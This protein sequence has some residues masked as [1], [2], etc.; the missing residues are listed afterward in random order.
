M[1]LA[2]VIILVSLSQAHHAVCGAEPTISVHTLDSLWSD[3]L[4]NEPISTRAILTLAKYPT[5]TTYFLE[6]HLKPLTLSREH[7]VELIDQ[8][9]SDNEQEWRSALRELEYFDPRLAFGLEE[10]LSLESAQRFPARHRLVDVLSGRSVDELYSAYNEKH[11]YIKLNNIGAEG[12]NFCG[13][14]KE[15]TCGSSW[16]A[17]HRIDRLNVLPWGTKKREWTRI[18]RLLALLESIGTTDAEEI[19]DRIATGHPDAHPSKVAVSMIANR[20][21]K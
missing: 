17:E 1:P 14:E 12:F 11:K 10:L 2:C 8:L 19:I 15:D 5:E 13:S 20:A 4:E 3:L 18:V 9:G 21:S 6:T 7:A 16:W